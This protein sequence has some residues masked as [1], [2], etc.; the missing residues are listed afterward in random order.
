MV[1]SI[2]FR[3]VLYW[4]LKFVAYSWKFSMLLLC[5]LWNDWTILK[6]LYL[7]EQLQQELEYTLLMPDCHSKWTSKMQCGRD[8]TLE[9]RSAIKPC[10]KLGKN[11]R[12][13]YRMLQ[14]AFQPS[15]MN[16][17]PVFEWHKRFKEGR[18]SLRDDERCYRSKKANTPGLIGQRIRVRVRDT[19]LRF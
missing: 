10:F 11:A 7:N 2:W 17:A 8:D 15:C 5:S 14:T 9:E 19:M 13:T 4:H 12:E 16:Q 6:I 18:K 1:H 3:T